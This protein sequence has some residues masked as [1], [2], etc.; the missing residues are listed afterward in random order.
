MAKK[1]QTGVNGTSFSKEEW[2]HLEKLSDKDPIV[3]SFLELV[4]SVFTNAH[5][6]SYNTI[7]NTIGFLNQSLDSVTQL[8]ESMRPNIMENNQEKEFDAILKVA[9]AI[10][11]LNADLVSMRDNLFSQEDAQELESI[12]RTDKWANQKREEQR[13]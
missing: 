12:S 2:E 3:F 10:P 1:K 4:K 5:I 11:K 9:S 6:E 13:K 8:P 7:R